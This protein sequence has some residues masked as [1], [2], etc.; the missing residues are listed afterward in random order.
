ME[1]AELKAL[2][3]Q[4]A[5]I[6]ERLDQRSEAAVR[7]TE[8]T[9][10]DM[11]AHAQRLGA[12]TQSFTREVLH[13]LQQH[14]GE[15]VGQGLGDS[16]ERFN[17]QLLTGARTASL[18]AQALEHERAALGRE[19]RTWLWLGGGAV[20]LGSLL[21][22]GAAFHAL[23]SSRKEVERNRIEA[24]LLRAYNQADVTLCEGR[25]CANVDDQARRH[26]DRKQ[27]RTVRPRQAGDT[28]N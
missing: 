15:V 27:Y 1:V 25:L 22:V 23:A 19:R 14:A 4:L 6:T 3:V 20:L 9:G 21:A 26:G 28:P 12:S 18:A 17:A 5:A 13:V 24:A 8:Q 7:R 16:V 11:G 10:A 2:V